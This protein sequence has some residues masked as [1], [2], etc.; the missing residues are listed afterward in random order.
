MLRA[1]SVDY[2]Y[3]GSRAK[4][5][6]ALDLSIEA[7]SICGLLGANGAGKSTLLKLFG[8]FIEPHIGD[9]EVLGFKPSDRLPTFLS[10]MFFLAEETEA[11]SITPGEYFER[12]APFYPEFDSELFRELREK[13]KL[14][15]S[16]KLDRISLGQKKKFFLAF[17][18]ATNASLLILDEPTNGLDIPSKKIFQEVV[19]NHRS[20]DRSFIISTHQA[21]DIEG[22]V[23][24]LIILD[25]GK[26]ALSESLARISELLTFTMEDS[27]P[28]DALFYEQV[29]TSFATLRSNTDGRRNHIDLRLLYGFVTANSEKLA[30][31]FLSE[32]T[33]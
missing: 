6:S 9:C 19:R 33:M 24:T 23:D 29:G 20:V 21:N 2:S 25:E 8:G 17:G 27:M 26:V 18:I 12:F 11:P 22:L 30:D 32:V 10:K 28:E 1:N 3:H 14:S 4:L 5:L 16:E 31:I 7:G 13:F 15:S